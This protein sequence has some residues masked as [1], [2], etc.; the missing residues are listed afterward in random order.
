MDEGEEAQVL[1]VGGGQCGLAMAHELQVRTC[2]FTDI[3]MSHLFRSRSL[4]TTASSSRTPA[5]MPQIVGIS[6]II[7]DDQ[8]VGQSWRNRYDS[9]RL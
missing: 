8:G 1:I 7:V 2:C 9:L 6:F 5:L 4:F 3:V